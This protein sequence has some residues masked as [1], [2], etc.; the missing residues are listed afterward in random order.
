[1]KFSIALVAFIFSATV[2]NVHAQSKDAARYRKESEEMRKQVWAWDKPEF[3]RRDI[4]EQYK[5]ASKVIIAHHTQLTA[6]SKSKFQFYVVTFG[7]KKEQTLTEVVREMVKL[8]DKNAVADYSELSFT[9]FQKSSGFFYDAKT[10]IYVGA[11]IIKPDGS[12]KEMNADDI[13]LTKDEAKE[14]KAKL[15]I[16]DLQPG[17]IIDYFIASVKNLDNDFTAKSY[18]VI[19][20]DDAP[21]LSLSFHAELGKKF[22]IEY[23]GYNGAPELKVS[24]NDDKDII[25]DVEKTNM[26]P[27]ETSLWVAPG[28]QLPFIRMNISLGY[29]GMGSRYISAKTPG[30]INK[31]TGSDMAIDNKTAELL[32]MYYDNYWI[33]AARRQYGDIVNDAEKMAKQ[34]NLKYKDMS[35]E[36]K[37]A[38]LFYTFRFTKFLNFDIDILSKKINIGNYKFGNN[39]LNLYCILKAADLDGAILLSGYRTGIRVNEA[40]DADDVNAVAYLKGKNNYLNLESIYDIP[41]TIPEQIEGLTDTKSITFTNK[42]MKADNN[43]EAGP[44]LSTSTSGKNAHIENLKISLTADRNNLAIHRSTTLK[45]LYKADA[46]RDLILYEDFYEEERK[47]FNEDKSLI[48]SLEDGKKSKKYVDEVQSAFADARKKQKDNFVEEA[49]DW[50]NQDVT[51]LKDY[52]TDTLGVRHTAPDFVYSSTFNLNGLVKRA[53]NNIILEI[54]KIEGEPL[55]IKPAQRKRDIDV[56]MPFARSIEYNIEFQIPD[57]YTVEGIDALNKNVTNIAGYFTAEAS[58][59]GKVVTLKV[60]K[61]YLH[62]FEPAKN[63]D[64]IIEFTDAAGDWANTKLL[65]K[66]S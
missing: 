63:W 59:N 66:K 3:K 23:R 12:I 26:P 55:I 39:G 33:K 27:F 18:D 43:T 32:G 10:T 36:E 56:Y 30:E 42:A 37:A 6:D 2:T 45:G 11:R 46:Q 50:F 17:D 15:A 14:K 38:L 65:L 9:Q 19:L 61:H 64:K 51:D 57:G 58:T 62:N 47:A 40:M 1:M 24:K 53:G 52:K 5:N 8:N 48:E 41:F 54:G 29:R 49:R 34:M 60:K 7:V 28:L 16:P 21:V 22:A 44:K 4:P 25:V 35:D 13:V 20:F 31:L